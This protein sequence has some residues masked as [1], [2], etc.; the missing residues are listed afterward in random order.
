MGILLSVILMTKRIIRMAASLLVAAIFLSLK[1]SAEPVVSARNAI[2]L[3]ADT[4]DVLWSRNEEREALIA[5]TT[6]IMTGLIIAKECDLQEVVCVPKEAVGVEGS[7]LYL[8]E[9]EELTVEALLYGMM[10]HSGNDAAVALALH[11]SGELELFVERMNDRAKMLG[12]EHTKF[13]NPHGLDASEHYST[14]LD[15]ARLTAYAM[16]NDIFRMVVSAKTFEYENR[17]FTNHNKMLWRYP[18][19]IGVKTGYT[20]AAGRILV[21][22]AERNS[23]RLICVTISAPDDWNDHCKLFDYGF[24]KL[25]CFPAEVRKR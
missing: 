25:A 9:G 23:R 22:C 24:E 7:S 2:L 16:E 12:M 6:K 18:G 17:T 3:D 14:A 11:H 15:L 19:T 1:I 4:G 5:S 21:T 20:K 10:L 13:Q 8:T